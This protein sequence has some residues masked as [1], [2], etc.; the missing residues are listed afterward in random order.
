MKAI[1][2]LDVALG[3]LDELDETPLSQINSKLDRITDAVAAAKRNLVEAGDG[4][5]D[6]SRPHLNSSD[7]HGV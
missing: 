7:N 4:S 2:K 3:L 1:A 6:P 5:L